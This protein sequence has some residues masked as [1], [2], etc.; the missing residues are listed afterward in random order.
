MKNVNRYIRFEVETRM[1]P[2]QALFGGGS[3]ES[4]ENSNE[5]DGYHVATEDDIDLLARALGGM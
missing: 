2:F 5:E 1:S 3:T 4:N